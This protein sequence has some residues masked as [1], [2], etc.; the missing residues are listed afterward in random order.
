M[1]EWKELILS[2]MKQ[3]RRRYIKA[4]EI[5]QQLVVMLGKEYEI[6]DG[7]F[8]FA[9][10][11]EELVSEG[12]IIPIWARGDNHQ[13]PAVYNEYKLAQQ[14]ERNNTSH[15][16]RL[17]IRYPLFQM[18]K[19]KEE[20]VYQ[21]WKSYLDI[22]HTLLMKKQNP[23]GL[24]L[25]ANERSYEIFRDEKFLLSKQGEKLLSQ[26]GITLGDL[27]CRKTHEPFFEKHV[28]ARP[29]NILIIEN[30][31]TYDSI[32]ELLMS[33]VRTWFGVTIDMVIYGEGDKIHR[34]YT[35]IE[36]YDLDANY[37]VYYFGDLDA[38]GIWICTEVMK[39]DERVKPFVPF[40]QELISRYGDAPSKRLFEKKL[41][42]RLI[43]SSLNTFT[44]FFPSYDHEYLK[45]CVR[46]N[47]AAQYYIPQE[48]LNIEILYGLGKE[49]K[50]S[51]E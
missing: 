15:I 21:E 6:H 14:A 2:F 8:S 1:Q 7:Y 37:Q 3:H 18:G 13:N 39:L 22:I 27:H 4:I 28:T 41:S 5:E 48:G 24:V 34:S 9:K 40:Y 38:R 10:T 49:A 30:K 29:K 32:K 26:I 51:D 23:K 17:M 20:K 46:I 16:K 31:D 33:G 43:H 45:H 12:V 36:E 25:K 19:F 42:D 50:V 47:G 35:F 11:M 44:S